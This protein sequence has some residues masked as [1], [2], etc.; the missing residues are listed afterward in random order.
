[1]TIKVSQHTKRS[2]LTGKQTRYSISP[3]HI[4]Y[5]LA[6][7][8]ITHWKNHHQLVEFAIA[9]HGYG[10]SDSQCGITYPGDLDDYGREVE[11]VVIPAGQVQAYSD[12]F[13]VEEKNLAEIDYLLILKSFLEAIQEPQLAETI[14]H[15][16]EKK[17]TTL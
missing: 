3:D 2:G 5:Q 14:H 16:I 15:E 4:E 12:H 6:L 13:E 10:N 17:P 7:N 11:K 1:M 8:A 9:G